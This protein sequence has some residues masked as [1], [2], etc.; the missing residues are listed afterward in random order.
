PE[1]DSTD[2]VLTVHQFSQIQINSD[3][4]PLFFELEPVLRVNRPFPPIGD[5]IQ[6][7]F[8]VQRLPTDP[9]YVKRFLSEQDCR[10]S[11][12]FLWELEDDAF[13]ERLELV[14]V[15]SGRG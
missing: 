3:G 6:S 10:C 14:W 12:L 2:I 5:D 8:S 15:Y 11:E 1:T 9:D 7:H 4:A 13:E